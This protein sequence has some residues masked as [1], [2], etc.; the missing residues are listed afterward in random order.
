MKNQINKS[1]RIVGALRLTIWN[2][3][4][5]STQSKL[6]IYKACVRPVLTYAAETRADTTQTK[7][8]YRINEMKV[9]KIITGNMLLD[10]RK[11][12]DIHEECQIKDVVR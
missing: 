9:L 12:N 5:I 7:K 1:V 10:H 2:N 6:R 4:C 3:N 8:M 11:N